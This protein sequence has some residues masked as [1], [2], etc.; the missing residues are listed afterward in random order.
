MAELGLAQAE[1][2][3]TLP[4]IER[5][6]RRIGRDDASEPETP[7]LEERRPL[8]ERSEDAEPPRLGRWSNPG[9]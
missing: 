3:E 1:S 8:G 2:L 4:S 6:V 5:H 7:R 9:A